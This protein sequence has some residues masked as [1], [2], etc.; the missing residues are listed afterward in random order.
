MGVHSDT[1][2]VV[3]SALFFY[4]SHYP[5][6][7]AKIVAE[8]RKAFP[9]RSSIREGS[10]LESCGYRYA[11]LN[12]AMRV[13]TP[14]SRSP[15]RKVEQGRALVAGEYFPSGSDV[16][17]CVYAVHQK[18]P[19]FPDFFRFMPEGWIESELTVTPEQ[20]QLAAGALKPFLIGPRACA[21]RWLAMLEL[22]LTTAQILWT[23][24]FR[25]AKRTIRQFR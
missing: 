22:S 1:T 9:T 7:Y 18:K 20:C 11:C 10:P 17:C 14:T 8:T 4:L 19:F 23:V 16:G 6:V 25:R 13:S 5:D 21:G 15:S 2:S 24:D 3:L 12:E